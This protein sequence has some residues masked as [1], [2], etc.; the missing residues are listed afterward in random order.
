VAGWAVFKRLLRSGA[1]GAGASV[2]DLLLLTGLVQL[3]G[4]TP[5][6]ANVPA[7]LGG[8]VVMYFGQK[9]LAFRAHGKPTSREVLLFVAVQAGGLALTGLLFDLALR[10][11]PELSDH[12][13]V[14]RLI[15]TNL[16]WLCYSFPLWHWVFRRPVAPLPHGAER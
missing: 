3:A 8:A 10:F 12:Y 2:T 5:E 15:T 16:V 14:L 11:R 7:L 1:A 4:L 6:A 9:H 13:V